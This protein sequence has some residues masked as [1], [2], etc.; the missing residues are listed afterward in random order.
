ME[1]TVVAADSHIYERAAI[2]RW[3]QLGNNSSPL[4]R[5]IVEHA[6]LLIGAAVE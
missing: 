3:F 4:T 6:V 2:S 1:N 5:E